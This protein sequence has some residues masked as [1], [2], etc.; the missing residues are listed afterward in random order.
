LQAQIPAEFLAAPGA[1]GNYIQYIYA[2]PTFTNLRFGKWDDILKTPVADTL[3]YAAAIQHFARGVAYS[4][5]G[6]AA[7]ARKE[8]Q[9]LDK[10]AQSKLLEP[11]MDNFSSAKEA[12]AV[13]ILILQG[14]ISEDQKQFAAAIAY[15]QKAVVAE[16]HIIYNEPRDWAIPARQYLANV[17]IKAGKYTEAIAVSKHD[18]VINPHNGWSLTGLQLAYEHTNNTAG[19]KK[20]KSQLK[21]AWKIRDIEIERPVF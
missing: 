1:D 4:R 21:D 20:V 5:K 18:L 12:S 6:D 17:L 2:Q 3:A 10:L 14:V 16:D 7:M 9:T 8:L 11:A 15:L 13:A 19:L